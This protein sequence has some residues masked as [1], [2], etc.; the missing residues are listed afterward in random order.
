MTALLIALHVIAAILLIGP[1]AVGVS[2]FPSS[3]PV[4]GKPGSI[5][6]LRV[7]QRITE[8]YGYISAIVPVVGLAVFLTDMAT[9]G[10]QGQFHASILL[11][12]IAWALL[13]FMIVPRQ[14]AALKTV[15]AAHEGHAGDAATGTPADADLAKAK[16]QLSMFGG[17]FNLLWV[18]IAIL[19]F[20]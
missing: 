4:D 11:A 8:T 6:A 13:I 15:T 9:Y 16:K 12:V 1:V 14:K 3:L 20:I 5:G 7:T 19:M 10:R 2:I 17:I 18:I